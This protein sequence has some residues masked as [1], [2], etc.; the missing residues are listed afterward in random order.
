[1]AKW[2]ASEVVER[3]ASE[4]LELWGGVGFTTECPA[5]KYLRDAKIGKI[6]EGTSFVQLDT[7]AKHLLAEGA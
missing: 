5:E 1:L 4:C 3:V 6:Y 7:I 2:F